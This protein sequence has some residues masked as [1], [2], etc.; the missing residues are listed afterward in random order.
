MMQSQAQFVLGLTVATLCQTLSADTITVCLDG[1]CDF[2]DPSTAAASVS[3]GDVIEIAAGTYLLEESIGLITGATIRGAVGP[4]G[5]PATVLDGQD[6]VLVLGTAYADQSL[7]ENLVLTNGYGDYG[8]G[9]R[10][11]AS[12]DV[13]VRNCHFVG[14]HANWEGAGIRMSLGS[15]VTLVDCEVTGNIATHPQWPGQSRG[16]GVRIAGSG[17]TTL[18]L[19]GTRVCGNS[20]GVGGPQIMGGVPVNLGG[21]VTDDCDSCVITQLDADL[22]ADGIVGLGDLLIV[23]A[24][25]GDSGA[26][27]IDGDGSVGV[28]DLLA[29]LSDW[30]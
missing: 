30:S 13:V 8:G 19:D 20:D 16:A 23:M 5:E 26:A 14:N 28:G 18:V 17:D 10:F 11:V 6:Q 21:C 3:A 4:N 2:T 25:W 24:S 7:F 9:A 12:D 22:N 27:D 1:T 29:V 15:T